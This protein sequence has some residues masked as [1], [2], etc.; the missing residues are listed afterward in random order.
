[1]QHFTTQELRRRQAL[2]YDRPEDGDMDPRIPSGLMRVPEAARLA[3]HSP[4]VVWRRIRAGTLK[5]YGRPQ[6]IFVEDLLQPVT[7]RLCP[8]ERTPRKRAATKQGNHP[9]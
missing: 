4:F 3:G 2:L 5:A 8:S 1:M 7:P 6:K 9:A